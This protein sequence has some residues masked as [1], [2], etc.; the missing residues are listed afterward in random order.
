MPSIVSDRV[1]PPPPAV[2]TGYYTRGSSPTGS[3]SSSETWT[4]PTPR[5]PSLPSPQPRVLLNGTEYPGPPSSA[6]RTAGGSSTRTAFLWHTRAHA[7][8]SGSDD[9]N[10][11]LV[12][13]VPALGDR[14][15]ERDVRRVLGRHGVRST[16][17]DGDRDGEDAG[18]D[19]DELEREH[20]EREFEYEH[21]LDCVIVSRAGSPTPAPW[22]RQAAPRPRE[23]A[24]VGGPWQLAVPPHLDL[25]GTCF[26]PRGEFVYVASTGGIVEWSVRG[27]EKKWWHESA[28]A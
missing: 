10:A 11:P 14:D 21:E 8:T 7:S 12:V 25:A 22:R 2:P 1:S 13:Q 19:V 15:A 24:A 18:M 4:A 23:Q 5:P 27:A 28:W 16:G 17:P 3:G 9:E 20:E 26:D 6:R